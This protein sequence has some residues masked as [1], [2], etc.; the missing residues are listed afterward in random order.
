MRITVHDFSGHPFQA[1]LSR[2]LAR[3]GHEVE[4]LHAE[5]YVSGKGHLD[6][7]PDDPTRL[8]F[9]GIRLRLPFL[10]YSPLTRLRYEA[11]YGAEWIRRTRRGDAQVTIASNV[12]LVSHFRWAVW[13]QLQRHPW[14]FWHQDI[15]S[16]GLADEARSRLPRP[17]GAL[18]ARVFDRME[19]FCA[20]T[21]AH[22]VAIGDGFCETYDRWGVDPQRVSVISNW[23][24]LDKVR[25][26][27][28]AHHR[29]TELFGEAEGLRMLYAGTLGRKHNPMLLVEVL[30]AAHAQGLEAAMTVIS[31]GEAAD[32]LAALAQ[33]EPDLGLRVLP[34]QPAE[35]LPYVL[36]S[37]DVL[38]GLLEPDATMFSIPSK[39]LSYMAA[40][41]PILGLMPDDNPAAM[42]ILTTGGHVEVPTVDGAWACAEWLEKLAADTGAVATIGSRARAVAE[43]KFHLPTITQR[44]ESVLAA[45]LAPA[46]TARPERAAPQPERATGLVAS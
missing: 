45:S 5:Q 4:H 25:P 36:G 43:E 42:D 35:D 29:S 28:R 16:V 31:E 41:R 38:V 26:T 33:E 27:S 2:S 15:D 8:R 37:A 12:P 21:A 24:P 10:K 22:V 34:F 39:V 9:A 40:G 6:L 30:R 20:R 13:A 46:A 14:V 3:Q 7:L 32:S 17:L 1:E 11:A 19:R 44:F 23:A 18:A